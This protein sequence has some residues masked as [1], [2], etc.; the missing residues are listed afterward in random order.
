MLRTVIY[1]VALICLNSVI[2]DTASSEK[3]VCYYGTGLSNYS[4]PLPPGLDP[5]LCTHLIFIGSTIIDG[6][7]K[8]PKPTDPQMYYEK[9]PLMK[10]LN[11][12]LKVL[13]CNG[14]NF[15]GVLA[16]SQNRSRFANSSLPILRKYG[17]DGLDLDFEFPAWNGLPKSQKHSFSLLL[18]ELYE[19]FQQEAALTNKPRLMLTAAVVSTKEIIDASYEVPILA[20]VLDFINLMCYDYHAFAYYDPFT[21]FNS[22]LYPEEHDSIYGNRSI[23]FS[24]NY[25]VLKGMPKSKVVVGIPVYGHSYK[26]VFKS[27]HGVHA[28]SYGRGDNGGYVTYSQVCKYLQSNFTR[29]FNERCQVPYMYKDHLWISYEDEESINIKANWIKSHGYPGIM[30][31]SMNYDDYSGVCDGGK[32]KNP[33]LKIINKF[34]L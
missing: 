32:T 24:A 6:Q 21:G 34:R 18:T 16:T 2:A 17:F 26:L 13:L 14:G 23:V 9:I 30:V 8:P 27:L 12:E 25:W 28:P 29:V 10:K 4:T 20:K 15:N 7:I 11:P 5:T 3:I 19:L 33:L 22:P 31:Y 1:I